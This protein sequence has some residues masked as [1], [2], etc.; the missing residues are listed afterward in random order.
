YVSPN[1]E[2]TK[3]GLFTEF[4][5]ERNCP[6]DAD[7]KF[8]H[9]FTTHQNLMRLL[10]ND[11]A[12]DPNREQTFSTPAN[13]KNKMLIATV[14]PKSPGGEA[15]MLIL[16][17]TGRLESMNQSVGYNDDAGIQFSADIKAEAEKL[18]DLP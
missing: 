10:I 2:T 7:P 14:N 15:W 6:E 18:D 16:D 12:M 8:E 17:T 3:R 13:S 5:L 1:P 11:P 9:L 4:F